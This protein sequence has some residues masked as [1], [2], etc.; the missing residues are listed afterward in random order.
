MVRRQNGRIENSFY[1]FWRDRSIREPLD[2]PAI[3]DRIG[4][5]HP[6]KLA[7]TVTST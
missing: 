6:L 7:V 4:C 1:L 5:L 3:P 2:R